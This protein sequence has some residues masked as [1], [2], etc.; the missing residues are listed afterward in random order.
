MYFLHRHATH[1]FVL[2]PNPHL[3]RE[4]QLA[5]VRRQLLDSLEDRREMAAEE[6]AAEEEAQ[7]WKQQAEDDSRREEESRGRGGY[8]RARGRGGAAPRA[9]Q[10]ARGPA[11]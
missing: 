11:G 8:G 9:P 1:A 3:T 5:W 4:Q 10:G 2:P 7:Q 6:K